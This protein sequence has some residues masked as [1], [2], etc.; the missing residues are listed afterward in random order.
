MSRLVNVHVYQHAILDFDDSG[1]AL[2]VDSEHITTELRLTN[3]VHFRQ[4]SS[5]LIYWKVGKGRFEYF[6][7]HR[8]PYVS[9]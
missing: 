2:Y 7:A 6:Q 9:M 1:K 8:L 4:F 3:L 5:L